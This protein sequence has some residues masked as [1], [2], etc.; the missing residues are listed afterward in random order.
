MSVAA[1][2]AGLAALV[3]LDSD[4]LLSGQSHYLTDPNVVDYV[5][6][7]AWSGSIGFAAGT[8]P[9]SDSH[10]EI[11]ANMEPRRQRNILVHQSVTAILTAV[12]ATGGHVLAVGEPT[13]QV[14]SS[15]GFSARSLVQHSHVLAMGRRVSF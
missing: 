7:L 12:H 9:R 6:R 13:V 2:K 15:L 10:A 3:P 4:P 5:L 14:C 8:P 11:L 1:I